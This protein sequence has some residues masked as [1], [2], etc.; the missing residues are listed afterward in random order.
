MVQDVEDKKKYNRKTVALSDVTDDTKIENR[1]I[2]IPE[3]ITRKEE[4]IIRLN[5][6][7]RDRDFHLS[8][9]TAFMSDHENIED[10]FPQ[11]FLIYDKLNNGERS[12]SNRKSEI[13]QMLAPS[14]YLLMSE[15]V[16][17]LKLHQ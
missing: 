9:I 8:L 7:L 10:E 4:D 5:T 1:I 17:R 2:I 6:S 15:G 12:A 16:A 13:L 3:P 14:R 11:V